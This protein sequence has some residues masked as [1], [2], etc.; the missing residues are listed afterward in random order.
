[1]ARLRDDVRAY[2]ERLDD[3]ERLAGQDPLTGLD[4]RRRVEASIEY[5]MGQKKV[6]SVLLLD[7]NGFKQLNDTCGH[8]AADE[9]LK[10]LSAELKSVFRAD[11]VVGRLGGDKFIVVL[12]AG[13]TD[14]N[15]HIERISRWVFGDYTIR[16]GDTSRK[17][18]V[19][20]AIGAAEWQAGDSRRTLLVR[21]DAAMYRDKRAGTQSRAAQKSQGKSDEKADREAGKNKSAKLPMLA[22]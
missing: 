16:V 22:R 19:S 18:A 11:D 7:L 14:A 6:F 20:A 13:L 4:N 17:V 1:V 15:A 12:D 8:Q 2:Q 3:A 9:L 21:A 10:Q 5:R